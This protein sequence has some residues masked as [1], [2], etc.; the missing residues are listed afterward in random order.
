[1]NS[2]NREGKRLLEELDFIAGGPAAVELPENVGVVE[3]VVEPDTKLMLAPR[4]VGEFSAVGGS[5]L[6]I[7]TEESDAKL[8]LAPRGVGEFS[9]V[10]GSWVAIT[11]EES[12]AK[13]M[14]AP[15]GVGE[16][17]VFGWS[18]LASTTMEVGV[19]DS[20]VSVIARITLVEETGSGEI[21]AVC[22]RVDEATSLCSSARLC[23]TARALQ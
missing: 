21:V 17:S 9:A 4:G 3:G 7:T 19:I 5:W 18:W 6:A 2:R 11:T 23:S 1:M 10:G 20:V 16:F 14:L 12:D 8:M 13:L 15:R 22:V